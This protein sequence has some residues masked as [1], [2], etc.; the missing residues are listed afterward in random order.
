MLR[1]RVEE[2]EKK[3]LKTVFPIWELNV[4]INLEV[5]KKLERANLRGQMYHDSF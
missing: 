4:V 3:S 5:N 2:E 1:G